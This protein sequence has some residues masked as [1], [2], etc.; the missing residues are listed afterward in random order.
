MNSLAV[1]A[2]CVDLC[3]Q[4]VITRVLRDFLPR[5]APWPNPLRSDR[6]SVEHQRAPGAVSAG[7]EKVV[8]CSFYPQVV[9]RVSDVGWVLPPGGG[10]VTDVLGDEPVHKL[11]RDIASALRR[12]PA[13]EPQLAGILREV[14]Q[15]SPRL[16][17]AL[18]RSVALFVKRGSF[19]RTLY[20]AAA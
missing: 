6:A 8:P 19:D 2:W 9:T 12:R 15:F 18:E 14:A 1:L 11:E 3:K 16:L 17:E 13:H 20:A 7:P 5:H 4:S 10:S